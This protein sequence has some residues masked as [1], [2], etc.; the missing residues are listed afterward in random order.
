M[1]AC[2]ECGEPATYEH[3]VVPRVRGGTRVVPLCGKCHGLAHHR[4]R[5]MNTSNL[6]TEALARLRQAGRAYCGTSPY[7]W[8]RVGAALVEDAD[9]QAVIVEIRELRAG[10]WSLRKISELF[11]ARGIFDRNG[12]PLSRELIWDIARRSRAIDK[13]ASAAA[14]H[15]RHPT[16]ARQGSL[17]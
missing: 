17:W 10:G 4:E 14:I 8:R 5:A 3:H 9:E 13:K 7:G 1:S 11:A 12:S 15:D 16:L 2:F 6:T